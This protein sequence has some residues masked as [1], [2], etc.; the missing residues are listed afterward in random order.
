VRISQQEAVDIAKTKCCKT[1]FSEC[2]LEYNAF[3][4][5]T[6][7]AQKNKTKQASLIFMS[8]RTSS[9]GLFT[10]WKLQHK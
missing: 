5:G 10:S 7:N 2:N 1:R 6:G 9:F 3:A 8:D 4:I